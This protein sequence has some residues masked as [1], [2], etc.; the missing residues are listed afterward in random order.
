MTIDEETGKDKV[1]PGLMACGEAACVSVH[2]ANRLGANSLLDLVVFGRAVA[3]TISDVLQ[4]GLPHI[5]LAS[6]IGHESI[7]NLDRVRNNCGSKK[8]SQI[9]LDMQ[10]TMQKDVSV[11]RMQETLDEGVKNI[12]EVENTFKDVHVSDKSMIWN[13]DLVETLELQNLLT[14]ARQTAVSAAK[15]KESRG[16]HAREDYPNRDDVNWRKHTLSWQDGT[17]KPVKI[18]Y[19]NVIAHT[20]DEN[21]CCPVPPAVRSY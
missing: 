8:T 2:G 15:R 11:F 1:I 17:S 18:K 7:A 10:R 4:P 21:E 5:P 20:L 14:C 19:R 13:S 9:R 16:A 3:S 6:N 12:A